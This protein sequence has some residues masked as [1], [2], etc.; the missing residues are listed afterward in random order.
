MK[1]LTL[2]PPF[3]PRYSRQSRSPCVSKGGTF[4]MPYFLAYATGVLEKNGFAVSL[5]DAVAKQW[6]SDETVEFAK[7]LNPNLVVV[8]TSTPSIF[9]DVEIAYKIKNAV[10]GAHVS[11]VGTHPTASPE[12]TLKMS[13][14]IDSV[15]RGE[16]DY[17]VLDLARKIESGGDLRT[18][19]GISFRFGEKLIHNKI[20]PLIK[21]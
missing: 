4:Y 17:T 21:D 1:V 19:D 2:N 15:C 20:R 7:Q 6:S 9:N 5:I 14:N 3:L 11:L 16:Y 13:A 8:D 10:N 18:V 12:E